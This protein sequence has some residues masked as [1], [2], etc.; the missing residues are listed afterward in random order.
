LWFNERITNDGA[1]LTYK[2]NIAAQLQS[3]RSEHSEALIEL[4]RYRLLVESV[5][6]Y[7]IFVI[8]P[9]GY[10]L[11]WN[12]GA[13]KNK[14]YKAHEIIG[15]HFSTSPSASWSLPGALVVSRTKTG[16]YA[17]T[18]RSFG[19][20]W[21]LRRSTTKPASILVLPR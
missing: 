12:R 7:A 15:K 19:P 20:T 17:K 1:S 10:I 11:T 16:V 9:E 2:V 4:E 8:D 21:S 13:E 6:D 3:L 5:Q 14:G 18:A